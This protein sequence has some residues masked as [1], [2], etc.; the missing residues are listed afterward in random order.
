MRMFNL[1]LAILGTVAFAF[2]PG[3][4][5]LAIEW[6]GERFVDLDAAAFNT[7]NAVWDNTGTYTDFEAVGD[8]GAA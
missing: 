5:S 1:C 6:A 2:G 8:P 4:A 3:K 7:G